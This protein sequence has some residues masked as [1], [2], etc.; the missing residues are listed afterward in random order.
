M[1]NAARRENPLLHVSTALVRGAAVNASPTPVQDRSPDRGGVEGKQPARPAGPPSGDRSR[2]RRA[3]VDSAPLRVI[4]PDHRVNTTGPVVVGVDGTCGEAMLPSSSH[5]K[6]QLRAGRDCWRYTPGSRPGCCSPRYPPGHP[7][8][9]SIRRPSTRV[10]AVTVGVR[11]PS[12]YK[13]PQVARRTGASAGSLSARAAGAQPHCID[14]HGGRAAYDSAQRWTALVLGLTSPALTVHSACPVVVVREAPVPPRQ[15]CAG[16]FRTQLQPATHR[17][18]SAGPDLPPM[19]PGWSLPPCPEPV[20]GRPDLRAPAADPHCSGPSH[21]ADHRTRRRAIL[22][23][24]GTFTER[25]A[26]SL[27][28]RLE[29]RG[30]GPDVTLDAR[31]FRGMPIAGQPA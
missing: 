18:T 31:S 24:E 7:V 1:A 22:G 27:I 15:S 19:K 9:G 23:P 14:R 28:Q 12:G 6:R 29:Q 26:R 13:Y 10:A 16:D 21:H 5:S 11:L 25:A 2:S 20:P 8:P 17:R 3:A 4:H 30:V